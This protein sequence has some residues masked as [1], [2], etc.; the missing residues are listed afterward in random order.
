MMRHT[1]PRIRQTI[2]QISHNLESANETAQ[3]GIYTFSHNYISPCLASVKSCVESCTAPC[4]PSREDQLRRRRRGRFGGRAELNFDFYD[5][6]DYDEDATGDALLGLGWGNDELDRLLAGSGSSSGAG[7]VG[8]SSIEQQP[9]GRH[10]RMSYGA[11]G[12]RRKSAVLAGDEGQDPTVIPSSPF[13]GFL[14]RFPWRIGARGI[15]Y[16]PSAADLQEN[17]G[18]VRRSNLEESEPLIE[19]SE[20][21]D[22]ESSKGNGGGRATP[23]TKGRSRSATQSSHETSNSL[24]SRGDLIPSDEEGD[25]VPL[26]DE[27]TMTLGRRD[28]GSGF[29]DHP[30]TSRSA[31]GT[32]MKT[33]GSS[34]N[35]KTSGKGKGKRR[36][37]SRKTVSSK[38]PRSSASDGDMVETVHIP[39][40]LDLKRE[41]EQAQYEEELQIEQKRLA[42][43]KLA[44]T[45]GLSISKDDREPENE[46]DDDIP[47][48]PERLQAQQPQQPHDDSTH[49]ISPTTSPANPSPAD[50]L[51]QMADTED[52]LRPPD[53]HFHDDEPET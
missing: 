28:T 44:R 47:H 21:S 16:R 36:R 29:P 5:D 50:P 22:R 39:S 27:F 17:P 35:S 2:N 52:P 53:G 1:D 38:S 34:K 13:L 37:N 4:F 15:R 11:R 43:Q 23:V 7:G 18:G 51:S 49:D 14:E 6:W 45:R 40:M 33:T 46:H 31:S 19:G 24:S 48:E 12:G 42:A 8:R 9:G 20:E 26:D 41:E 30:I 25:A 32:S 3:E 10:R